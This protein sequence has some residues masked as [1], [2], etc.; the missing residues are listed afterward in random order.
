M[1]CDCRVV[2]IVATALMRMSMGRASLDHGVIM[3]MMFMIMVTMVVTVVMTLVETVVMT[4]AVM[5]RVCV[6]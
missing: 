6:S 1:S 4:V 3:L 2:M 5:I